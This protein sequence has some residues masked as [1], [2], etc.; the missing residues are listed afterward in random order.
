MECVA[1][2]HGSVA[3]VKVRVDPRLLVHLQGPVE[4][5]EC[6]GKLLHVLK[7]HAD[8]VQGAC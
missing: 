5:L 6:F 1:P 3:L 8:I 2:L 7:C 4:V